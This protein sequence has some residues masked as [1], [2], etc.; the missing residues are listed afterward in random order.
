MRWLALRHRDPRPIEPLELID[1]STLEVVELDATGRLH[2]PTSEAAAASHP[3]E[4]GY[5]PRERDPTSLAGVW[6]A[7]AGS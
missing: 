1:P 4:I 5:A 6:E 2:G 3:P 7:L